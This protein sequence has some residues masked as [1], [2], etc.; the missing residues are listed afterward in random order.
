MYMTRGI[1]QT[2][3][4]VIFAA[5]VYFWIFLEES[6]RTIPIFVLVLLF[7]LLSVEYVREGF[8]HKKT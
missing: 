5:I 6:Q 4:G 1:F 3:A 7:I 2:L 8:S